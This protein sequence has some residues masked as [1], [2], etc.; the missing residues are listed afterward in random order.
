MLRPK[1]RNYVDLSNAVQFIQEKYS[2]PQSVMSK[3]EDIVKDG[4]GQ[5]TLVDIDQDCYEPFSE[6]SNVAQ[7]FTLEFG[8]D[9][10][11]EWWW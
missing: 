11:Y 4:V 1:V 5:D 9:T 8:E 6:L 7:F 2:V 3:L 10:R